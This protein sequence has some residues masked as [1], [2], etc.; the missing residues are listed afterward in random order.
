M[1][2]FRW[3][4][5]LLLLVSAMSFMFY[6]GTGQPRFRRFGLIILKWTLIAAFGFFAVLILERVA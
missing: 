6:A 4:V 3:L 1:L 5:L 2:L